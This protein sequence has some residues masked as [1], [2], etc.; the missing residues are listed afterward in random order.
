MVYCN[1]AI[2]ERT[3]VKM[4][5]IVIVTGIETIIEEA[6]DKLQNSSIAELLLQFIKGTQP[7]CK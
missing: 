4:N 5:K 7:V 6:S 3:L 1:P 2:W